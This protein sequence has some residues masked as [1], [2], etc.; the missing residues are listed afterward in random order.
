[1]KKFAI[2]GSMSIVV[3][4]AL[5]LL[6]PQPAK[7]DTLDFAS[8]YSGTNQLSTSQT[9]N[10]D[11]T[12]I[13]AYAY[14]CSTASCAGGGSGTLTDLS[15]KNLGSTGE[16]GLGV[17]ND[18]DGSY[19][20]SDDSFLTLDLS[21]L[22]T[23]S[24]TLYISSVQQSPDQTFEVCTSSTLG[25]LGTCSGPLPTTFTSSETYGIPITWSSNSPYVSIVGSVNDSGQTEISSDDVLVN[26]ISTPEPS[27]F[28]M[29]GLGLLGLAC[30]SLLRTKA[31]QSMAGI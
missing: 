11:G 29:L 20:I 26:A 4:V 13:T 30:F 12:T 3:V 25:S 21:N 17:Y 2:L 27:T 9:F 14:D 23:N 16:Q 22:T 5:C 6:N 1:M 10:F 8:G 24:G 15:A 18:A 7:A 19:E 28:L 31:G